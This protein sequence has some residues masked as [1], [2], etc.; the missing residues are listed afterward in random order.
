MIFATA[1]I[2]AQAAER[3]GISKIDHIVIVVQ[4]NRSF[5]NLFRGFPNA[6]SASRGRLPN[7]KT[8]ALKPVSL[9]AAY[10][11][12]HS[13]QDA[14]TAYD[15]DRMDG[16]ANEYSS[17]TSPSDPYPQYAYVPRPEVAPY[18]SMARQYVLADRMFASQLDGSFV[19]HQYLIAGWA[20]RSY[21]YPAAEP[22]GCD[23][24][25]GN[26]IGLLDSIGQPFGI[27]YP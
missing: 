12:S 22:W 2:A 20:G 25:A 7:G 19:A 4:E 3:T 6:H 11:I 18:W 21:N 10:D 9:A 8:V 17:G 27:T 16:F 26:A 14:K 15:G 5:D 1:S 23:S 24:P 13:L